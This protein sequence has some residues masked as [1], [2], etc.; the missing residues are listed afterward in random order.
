ML[1]NR[2]FGVQS[3][4]QGSPS[5]G[6]QVGLQTARNPF[7]KEFFA[8]Y[9]FWVKKSQT[10]VVGRKISYRIMKQA[11]FLSADLHSSVDAVVDVLGRTAHAWFNGNCCKLECKSAISVDVNKER[12]IAMLKPRFESEN[13]C[14]HIAS[15]DTDNLIVNTA[16]EAATDHTTTVVVG[17]NIDLLALLVALS[18]TG[19]EIYFLKPAIGKNQKSIYHIAE[20]QEHADL[21]EAILT[22]HAMTGCDRLRPASLGEVKSMLSNYSAVRNWRTYEELF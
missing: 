21:K 11:A 15:A 2:V 14:V 17:Q 12:L 9:T 1:S 13:Y 6:L 10:K 8:K 4:I 22:A 3:T 19:L 18:P 7:S 5:P 20:L 16:I